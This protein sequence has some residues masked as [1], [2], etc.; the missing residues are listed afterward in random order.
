[1]VH[2]L[3]E[4]KDNKLSQ[5]HTTG[6]LGEVAVATSDQKMRLQTIL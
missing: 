1:M 6:N 4:K 5:V 3:Y 2:R